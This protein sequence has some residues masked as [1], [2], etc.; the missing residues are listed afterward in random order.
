MTNATTNTFGDVTLVEVVYN[1]GL[2]E[3]SV[4]R[5]DVIP[6]AGAVLWGVISH[7]P[8]NRKW[9]IYGQTISRW[10]E[11]SKRDAIGFAVAA[12]ELAI[13]RLEKPL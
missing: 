4:Y 13:N 7:M 3:I 5:P 2:T 10:S 6:G 11:R 12:C 8:H 1:T 9:F